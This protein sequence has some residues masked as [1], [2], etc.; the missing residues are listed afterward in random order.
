MWEERLLELA[1]EARERGEE[2]LTRAESFQDAHA[3]QK[4]HEIAAEYERL[5]E[6]LERAAAET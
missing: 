2:V 4:M 5:A 1:R 3:R 6:R